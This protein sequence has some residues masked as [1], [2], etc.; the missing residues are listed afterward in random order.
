MGHVIKTSPDDSGLIIGVHCTMRG[1]PPWE[2]TLGGNVGRAVIMHMEFA[3]KIAGGNIPIGGT[4]RPMALILLGQYGVLMHNWTDPWKKRREV[5]LQP[6]R[7]KTV[8]MPLE[9][10]T[11]ILRTYSNKTRP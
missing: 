11:S 1:I 3:F 7:L 6:L 4:R 9:S 8:K 10:A 2:G 5:T